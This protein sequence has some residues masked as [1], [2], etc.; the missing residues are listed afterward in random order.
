MMAYNIWRY[1]KMLAQLSTKGVDDDKAAGL[2]GVMDN[3]IRIARLKLL[4]IAAKLVRPGNRDQVRYSIHDARTPGLLMFYEF[5][6]RLRSE[7]VSGM[8][9]INQ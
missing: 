5:L 6:D 1:F 2:K 8:A 4:V 3:T 9:L 7:K